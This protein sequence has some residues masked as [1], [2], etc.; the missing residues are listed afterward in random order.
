MPPRTRLIVCR[1][2]L[3]FILRLCPR[4]GPGAT[5]LIFLLLA[6]GAQSQAPA[7]NSQLSPADAAEPGS[8]QGTVTGKDGEVYEGVRVEL[9][10]AGEQPPVA[11]ETDSGGEFSFVNLPAGA[12]TLTITSQGFVTQTRSG[13]LNPGESYD[14]HTVVLPMM[15]ASSSVFVSAEQQEQIAEEQ[16]HIEE[17]QRVLGVLPNYYVSYEKSP[18]PLTRRQKFGL[19]WKTSID[20]YTWILNGITAG[21]EQADNGLAGYGQGMQGFGKRLG[22]AGADTFVSNE[23]GG[24]ILPSLFRQDPRYFYKGTGTF[25]ARA[26]YAIAT[27][28]IC[29]GDNMRWQFNA[30]GILGGLAAGGVSNLYYPASNRSS[31]A[32]TFENAG[33]GLAESAVQNLLQ[34]FVVK[35]FTPSARRSASR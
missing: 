2:K 19:A 26:A 23:I 32:L 27:T 8:I 34:E 24:A 11:T 16:I 35:K 17:K 7:V 14:T 9:V 22:A 33:I 29:K 31:V 5:A 15:G 6:F 12:F 10:V 21:F 25:R 4:L 13:V 28:V 30:S 18:A 1:E 20:P 3:A